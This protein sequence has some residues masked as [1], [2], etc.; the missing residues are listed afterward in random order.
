MPDLT[1]RTRHSQDLLLLSA[2]PASGGA[3]SE[4]LVVPG[5]LSTDSV[6]SVSH[7]SGGT[8]TVAVTG[9]SAVLDG[10]LTVAF[11]ADPG[12]GAV[13]QVAVLR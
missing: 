10:G 7:V 5:L 8:A 2:N 4:D 3:A 12:A 9:W 13:V 11:T 6:V 1:I